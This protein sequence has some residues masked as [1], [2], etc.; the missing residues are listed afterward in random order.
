MNVGTEA[1]YLFGYPG[2]GVY[3]ASN[4]LLPLDYHWGG[5]QEVTDAAPTRVGL[6]PGGTAYVLVNKYRCDLGI[7][8]AGITLQLIPPDDTKSLVLNI[9]N[10]MSEDYCVPGADGSTLSISP[11]EPTVQATLSG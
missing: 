3:D 1:C 5:D 8:D 10:L 2:I 6:A 7:G 4:R 9:Q 11:I